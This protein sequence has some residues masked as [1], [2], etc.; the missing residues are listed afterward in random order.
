LCQRKERRKRK[1]E[2][3]KKGTT[4]KNGGFGMNYE[5]YPRRKQENT[6]K[7]R[8]KNK[9]DLQNKRCDERERK[10]GEK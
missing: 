8:I 3:R 10:C 9:I 4:R 7:N 1:N 6:K 2:T 5:K